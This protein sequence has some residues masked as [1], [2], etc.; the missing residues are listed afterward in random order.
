MLAPV[1]PHFKSENREVWREGIGSWDIL[2]TPNRGD[3]SLR[4]KFLRKF[5][6][7]ILILSFLSPH[8]CTHNVKILPKRT[9]F[10]MHQRHKISSEPHKGP[11]GIA[12]P[13]R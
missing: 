13:Q 8:F 6:T 11:V 1:S 7:T 3:L 2:P 4:D 9:D 5:L 10:G 12:L